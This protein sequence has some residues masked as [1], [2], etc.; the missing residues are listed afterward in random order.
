M[1]SNGHLKTR[2]KEEGELGKIEQKGHKRRGPRGGSWGRDCRL[3]S[4]R[5][6]RKKGEPFLNI[7]GPG[8]E[9]LS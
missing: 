6:K 1:F 8:G 4:F 5:A 9:K 2:K 3:P 7:R